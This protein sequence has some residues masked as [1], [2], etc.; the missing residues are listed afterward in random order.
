MIGNG[1]LVIVVALF[2]VRLN[3]LRRFWRLPA[4]H[5]EEMFLGTRVPAGFHRG[6]GA[7]LLRQYRRALVVPFL[8]DVPLCIFFLVNDRYMAAVYEQFI[9]MIVTSIAGNLI[10]AHFSVRARALSGDGATP[11]PTAVQLSMTP[12]RLRDHTNWLVEAIIGLCLALCFVLLARSPQPGTGLL[13]IP[14]AAAWLLYLEVGLLLLKGVFVR[15]RMPLPMNREEDF[16]RWRAAWLRYHLRIFD[17]LRLSLACLLLAALAVSTGVIAW[18]STASLAVAA[19]AG[20]GFIALIVY[21]SGERRRLRQL[22][23]ELR[24]VEL[25]KEFPQRPIAEGRFLAG[26]LLYLNRDNPGVLVRS[27]QGIAINLAQPATYLWVAYLAGLV[28]LAAWQ[29]TGG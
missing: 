16:R 28:A 6:A 24:P 5:G 19:G 9:A 3:A 12:R 4:R 17:A 18:G 11:S 26:G 15:W 14:P 8:V 22:E 21:C 7:H 20:L 29:V 23:Q 27:G 13:S 25:V 10:V 2:A 1:L